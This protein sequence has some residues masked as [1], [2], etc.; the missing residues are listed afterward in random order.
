VAPPARDRIL[1]AARE[2]FARSPT[3]QGVTVARVASAAGLSRATVYR[4]FPSRA[5]LRVALRTSSD[6]AADAPAATPR[7]Q[8]LDAALAVFAERGIHAT[9]LRDV[10]ARAGLSLSGVHWYFKNK[11]ELIGGIV[12]HVRVLPTIAQEAAL[13]TSTGAPDLKTQLTHIAE[14][15][16]TAMGGRGGLL[17]L[18]LCEAVHHPDVARLIVQQVAGRA[19]PLLAQI[20]DEHARRGTIRPGPSLV[21]AQAFVGML[22]TR[23]L[24]DPLIGPLLPE[25]R[26]CAEEYVRLVVGGVAAEKEAR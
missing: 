18:G 19:L 1:D 16:V 14:V 11:E 13:A 12:A 6:G 24:L 2:L 9:S 17:R 23:V 7:E 3:G 20:F 21:R 5:D 8:I 22:M 10:A 25:L 4:H 26:V 15:M